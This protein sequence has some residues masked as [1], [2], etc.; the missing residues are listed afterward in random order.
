M[1]GGIGLA[2][3]FNAL[4]V[5]LGPDYPLYGFQAKGIDGQTIPFLCLEEMAEHY[6][7][8]MKKLQPQGPYCIG[9]YSLGGVIAYEMAHRLK[10]KKEAVKAVIMLDTYPAVPEV[11]G[12]LK[13]ALDEMS[14]AVLQANIFSLT[15]QGGCPLIQPEDFEGIRPE[16]YRMHAARLMKERGHSVWSADE[17]YRRLNGITTAAEGM[18]EA[19]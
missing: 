2:H 10:K 16:L 5:K 14:T 15:E 17:W 7:Q 18:G 3:V 9:G 4:S 13:E 12:K 6:I 8:C 19:F 11:Y 1:H